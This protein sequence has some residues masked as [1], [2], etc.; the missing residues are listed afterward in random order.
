M[1]VKTI[2]ADALA[3]GFRRYPIDDHGKLRYLMAKL[4][5]TVDAGDDGSVG[6]IGRLAPG[7]KRILPWLS[8]YK[9]SGTVFGAARV[10]KIGHRAY[11][12][13]SEAGVS[14][15]PED[16]DALAS[17]IDVSAAAQNMLATGASGIFKFDMFS[18]E[19]VE[20]F[21]T[22]TGGTWPVGSVVE[23]AIAY[24]YE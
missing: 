5:N 18:R 8:R 10:M 20:L 19:E 24:L 3:S 9:V 22:I 13:R 6:I 15:E 1:A 23:L 7:R 14:Q 17:G 12:A 16:D 11:D 2:T 4:T 21:L